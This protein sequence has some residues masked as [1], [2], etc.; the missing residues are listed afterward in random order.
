MNENK[1]TYTDDFYYEGF[2]YV[3]FINPVTR[4]VLISREKTL[5]RLNV[6]TPWVSLTSGI[7]KI[8][9]T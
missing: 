6:K 4:N 3:S 8:N 5:N 7:K 9:S 1:Q 2:P